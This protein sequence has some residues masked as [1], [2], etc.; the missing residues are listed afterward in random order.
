MD[1]FA[2]CASGSQ[3]QKVQVEAE[4]EISG[5]AAVQ[6]RVPFDVVDLTQPSLEN[7]S[8]AG[9]GH[10]VI[11]AS[12]FL[13]AVL[14]GLYPFV[15]TAFCERDLPK[16]LENSKSDLTERLEALGVSGALRFWGLGQNLN[17]SL[18]V[19]F[20]I[21]AGSPHFA[22]KH[23]RVANRSEEPGF[24]LE[25]DLEFCAPA[26][27]CVRTPVG[28]FTVTSI[29]FMG[30][31]SFVLRPLTHA[32]PYFG[33][34]QVFFKDCPKFSIELE[35]DGVFGAVAPLL[36]SMLMKIG[37]DSVVN[38][39]VLPNRQHIDVAPPVDIAMTLNPLDFQFQRPVGVLRI[40]VLKAR[41]LVAADMPDLRQ[42]VET[43]LGTSDPFVEVS[44]GRQTVKTSVVPKTLNPDW[45]AAGAE[46]LLLVYDKEQSIRLE[47]YDKDDV[48]QAD[49]LGGIPGGVL[50]IERLYSQEFQDDV[51]DDEDEPQTV[52]GLWTSQEFGGY[53]LISSDWILGGNTVAVDW[54][55]KSISW[56]DDGETHI[57]QLDDSF[58]T[59]HWSDGDVWIKVSCLCRHPEDAGDTVRRFWA[60]LELEDVEEVPDEIL[61]RIKVEVEYLPLVAAPVPGGAAG[62]SGWK[63]ESVL[64]IDVHGLAGLPEYLRDKRP[65]IRIAV[66]DGSRDESKITP[67]GKIVPPKPVVEDMSSV[68]DLDPH[69]QDL[70]AKLH[71]QD[72]MSCEHLAALLSIPAPTVYLFLQTHLHMWIAYRQHYTFL[73]DA[74]NSTVVSFTLIGGLSNEELGASDDIKISQSLLSCESLLLGCGVMLRLKGHSDAD[75]TPSQMCYLRLTMKLGY[76]TDN[77]QT[78][79]GRGIGLRV[80]SD[81]DLGALAL[82]HGGNGRTTSLFAAQK[83]PK[84]E[85]KKVAGQPVPSPELPTLNEDDQEPPTVEGSVSKGGVRAYLEAARFSVRDARARGR[86]AAASA[87]AAVSRFWWR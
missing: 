1:L 5:F 30:E 15:V 83:P 43:G 87:R 3:E 67:R 74:V 32:P 20:K 86:A 55:Q 45:P 4:P 41:D 62:F 42:M 61:S 69:T 46:F 35:C 51:G 79:T 49:Y 17:D 80:Q 78:E 76:L 9:V 66:K 28:S 26:E 50:T 60:P 44:L 8:V 56:T 68:S 73:L 52:S 14:A 13:D 77:E 57:G 54:D 2:T 84:S 16:L 48:K 75:T 47:V 39:A 22:P 6:P 71:M 34:L 59:I 36:E 65:R 18:S 27:I 21:G 12:A 81:G 24:C 19:S 29:S 85:K 10:S 53:E 11:K 58:R 25:A 82:R 38:M 31:I 37:R 40:H 33:A 23:F 64:V 72:S 70:I 63:T 7:G